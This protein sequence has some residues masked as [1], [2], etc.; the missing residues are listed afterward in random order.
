MELAGRA[1]EFWKAR[2]AKQATIVYDLLDPSY[3]AQVPF[4]R[5]Q[6]MK[7]LWSYESHTLNWVEAADGVGRVKVTY[8]YR[9]ADPSMS[10]MD[11][12]TRSFLENWVK[13]AGT[14][15]RQVKKN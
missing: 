6:G 2:E 15:Y 1:D 10:K 8:K 11:L 12:K 13:V 7:D 4:E 14:W 9:F 3:R 5:F